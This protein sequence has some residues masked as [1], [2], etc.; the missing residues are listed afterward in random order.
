M[1]IPI[2]WYRGVNRFMVERDLR[3]NPDLELKLEQYRDKFIKWCINERF[4]Y[5]S[6]IIDE[7][8]TFIDKFISRKKKAV[9][10]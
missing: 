9:N 3:N 5:E 6:D 4:I 7:A 1:K 10:N 8:N 2:S